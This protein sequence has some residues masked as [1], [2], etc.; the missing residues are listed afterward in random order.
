MGMRLL[1]EPSRLA[2]RPLYCLL[3]VKNARHGPPPQRCLIA[4]TYCW[5]SRPLRGHRKKRVD[6]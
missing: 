6:T 3:S 1:G 5:G 4:A 2:L